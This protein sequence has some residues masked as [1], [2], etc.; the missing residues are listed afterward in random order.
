MVSGAVPELGFRRLPD[1][2]GRWCRLRRS[3]NPFVRSAHHL[4]GGSRPLHRNELAPTDRLVP[5][6]RV[7]RLHLLG[8]LKQ[9][10][11]GERIT[12]DSRLLALVVLALVVRLALNVQLV[13][14]DV[15]LVARLA[16]TMFSLPVMFSLPSTIFK[17]PSMFG[18]P[19][20]MFSA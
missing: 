9:I 13:L 8:P 7:D 3:S 12:E 16:M 1:R 4:T 14:V 2:L 10:L 15:Q 5:G 17:W 6:T 11:K 19:T 20:V 18:W